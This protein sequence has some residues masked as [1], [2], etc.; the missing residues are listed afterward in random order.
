MA[1]LVLV[2]LIVPVIPSAHGDGDAGA[3]DSNRVMSP[4]PS[5]DSS[6]DAQGPGA[7]AYGSSNLG[8]QYVDVVV[9]TTDAGELGRALRSIP[10]KGSVGTASGSGPS[11]PRIQIPS[12]AVDIVKSLPSTIGVYDYKA[13]ERHL[14]DS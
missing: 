10:H 11:T 13:P 3:G 1:L 6:A 9:F 5:A 4:Q 8:K 7:D 14:Y 12:W 2:F